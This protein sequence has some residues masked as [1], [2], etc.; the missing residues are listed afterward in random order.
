VRY[1][2]NLKGKLSCD[3]IRKNIDC[4]LM[5]FIDDVK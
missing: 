2:K 4:V 3:E 1:R 5:A